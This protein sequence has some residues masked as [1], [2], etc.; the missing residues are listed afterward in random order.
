MT[1]ESTAKRI[2]RLCKTI[3][4]DGFSLAKGV[5]W[6]NKRVNARPFH[7]PTGRLLAEQ[8]TKSGFQ[9]DA[10]YLY[11]DGSMLI[12]HRTLNKITL[13]STRGESK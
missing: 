6:Q 4:K 1:K 3:A 5:L 12:A 13:S 2:E 7:F 11:A 8:R 10:L 9:T